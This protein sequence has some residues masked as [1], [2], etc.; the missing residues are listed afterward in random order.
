MWLRWLK[1][2]AENGYVKRYVLS[3]L[4]HNNNV[5]Q[6]RGVSTGGKGGPS[7][8]PS[9]QKC[10]FSGGK[11]LFAFVKNVIQIAFLPQWR[12]FHSKSALRN[13]G[14]TNFLMLPT[15][16]TQDKTL[17]FL[18]AGDSLYSIA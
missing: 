1:T 17:D 10:H 14:H 5:T 15:P 7:P 4:D 16:L 18:D 9:F 11:V 3:L 2:R 6:D 12:P 13:R 8:P